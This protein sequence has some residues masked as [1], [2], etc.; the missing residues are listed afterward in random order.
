MNKLVSI[1]KRVESEWPESGIGALFNTVLNSGMD[2]SEMTTKFRIIMVLMSLLLLST[3]SA[4]AEGS[5]D[6]AFGVKGAAVTD[7]GIAD[8]EAMALAVQPDG[9]ILLAGFSD[10]SVLKDIAVARYL[11]DGKLDTTFHG[12]GF[13]TFNVGSGN[14]MARAMA[15]QDDGK[16]VIA[17]TSDNGAN[18]ASSEIF[19]VRLSDTGDPDPSFGTAGRLVLPLAGR[20]GI[21]YD[22]QLTADGD[23]LV[24]GTAGGSDS[25]QAMVA[26]VD[27]QGRLDGT[28]G[29]KGTVLIDRDYETAAHSLVVLSDNSILLA[30][31]SKQE[32]VAGLSLF[33][34]NA[35][36]AVDGSFGAGGEVRVAVQEGEA[37]VYDMVAQADG[38]VVVVGSF[39]N[40]RYREVLLGRFLANGQADASFGTAGLVRNDL[41]QDSVVYAVAVQPDGGILATGFSEMGNGK[42]V[43]LLRYGA[44]EAATQELTTASPATAGVDQL[45]NI[46]TTDQSQ[47][48]QDDSATAAETAGG[49]ATATFIADAVSAFDDE[50]RAL[51]IL[52]NGAVLA[53]GVTSNGDDNDFLLLQFSPNAVSSL[54]DSGTSETSG[55]PSTNFRISTTPIT[56]I[57]RNS[58]ISGGFITGRVPVDC[59]VACLD[60]CEVEDSDTNTF[61]TPCFSVC[62][63]RC[64]TSNQ[65][66]NQTI[67][68]RGVVFGTARH[69]VFR[70]TTG[71]TDD[72]GNTPDD[73]DPGGL[74]I[75]PTAS[76]DNSHNF[77]TV[78]FGQTSDGTGIGSFGSHI[79]NIT[80]D[81]LYFVRAYAVLSDD[82]VIYGNELS[83][84]TEDACFIATAAYG[85][86]LDPHV[87]VLR[88]FRDSY[89]K[90]SSIGQALINGYYQFSPAIA[91]VIQHNEVLKQVV[92][93]CLWPWVAFCYLMLHFAGLVKF[94]M[95]LLAVLFAGVA[96]YFL[97]TNIKLRKTA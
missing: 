97:K 48:P 39:D 62:L 33:R 34:L 51:A 12:A 77:D 38:R 43:I 59:E 2:M 13:T 32:E 17:G 90:G 22:L 1:R 89:L 5:L 58:A 64:N 26:R 69:P 61:T 42:D 49:A 87:V 19:L 72:S 86:L 70:P 7:F 15:V 46:L 60:E 80:P 23:I 21:A 78:L 14:A 68:A 85:S 81:T 30:G 76:D 65:G 92:R 3:V 41:G 20:T 25:L 79:I 52:P 54:S 94:A 55:V 40:G 83:F 53:A 8:D 24:A 6:P 67:T 28:F 63:N 88:N 56:N 47:T 71:T 57:T 73:S 74:P 35:D 95:M 44:G 50:G 10:T 11:P 82:R 31:Y 36:G 9:K 37:I 93:L 4:Y 29:N 16:I 66:V 75:L 96:A 18:E 84:K 27:Q 91:E 45:A